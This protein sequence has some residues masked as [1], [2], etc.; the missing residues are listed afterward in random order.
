MTR[1]VV[2][3]E[4]AV[5]TVGLR[6]AAGKATITVSPEPVYVEPLSSEK[7]PPA[8]KGLDWLRKKGSGR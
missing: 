1:A 2:I 6:A 8:K 7:D 5:D 4:G 3:K